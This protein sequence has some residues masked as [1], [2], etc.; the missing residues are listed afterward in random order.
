MVRVLH[1][2]D[3]HLGWEPKYLPEHKSKLIRKERDLILQKAV[4]FALAPQNHIHGVLIVG[5]LFERYNPEESLV[6]E[7]MRQLQRLVANDKWCVTVPGNHDE[8][9]YYNSVYRVQGHQWPGVLVTNPM[10]E[11]CFS[12]VVEGTP[13]HVYSLAYTGGL[14]KANQMSGFPYIQEGGFHIGAFHG[15][16]DWDGLADRSL[17]LS[18]ASLA[19]AKYQ[20]IALGHYHTYMEKQV[21][22]GKAVYPGGIGLKTVGDPGVGFFTVVQWNG[23]EVGI[24]KVP[25][26]VRQFKKRSLDVSLLANQEELLVEISKIA[27][28]EDL[29]SLTLE[30]NPPFQINEELLNVVLEPLFFYVEWNN[31]TQFFS[32]AYL[33]ALSLEQTI[34][35]H[36]VRRM[37]EK[38]KVAQ[39]PGER[40]LVEQALLK[41]L[42]ALEGGK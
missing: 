3:L 23:A 24:E 19:S 15:S 18:S 25:V 40:A 9:T 2:A 38:M 33:Q 42:Q 37:Q 39:D 4:D 26:D 5:D 13:V 27:N 8:I 35:G 16:L 29:V 7:T 12:T 20:Y 28:P 14:T 6:R 30:G 32:E 22:L 36:F 31:Q 17:P 11:H 34:R 21:G 1:L 10:P 41:G